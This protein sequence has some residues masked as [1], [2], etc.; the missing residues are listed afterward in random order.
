MIKL[1]LIA[2]AIFLAGFIL[3]TL[4]KSINN[5]ASRKENYF[6]RKY[7]L[8][9]SEQSFYLTLK[10]ILSE[11]YDIF[12]KP[13]MIDVIGANKHGKPRVIQKHIDFV[14]TRKNHP[15]LAIELDDSSHNSPYRKKQDK[16]KNDIFEA[17]NFPY[18]RIS[19]QKYYNT[20]ELK[21][22]I[23]ASLNEHN[24]IDNIQHPVSKTC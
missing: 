2:G 24:R 14:I 15:I 20:N 7:F 18:I 13:R 21:K 8:S 6:I 10:H 3:N 17:A 9:I 23:E 5:T 19:A 11:E 22:R 4:N 1:F 12:P 16:A